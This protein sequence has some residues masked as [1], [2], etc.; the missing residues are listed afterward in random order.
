M[1]S[2]ASVITLGLGSFGSTSLLLTLGYESDE[3]GDAVAFWTPAKRPTV[4]TPKDR[5][6]VWTA[7]QKRGAS[8]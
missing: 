7:S 4:W 3:V 6:E 2:P 1:A 8:Q 5:P